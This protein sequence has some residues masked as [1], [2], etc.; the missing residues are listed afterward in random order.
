[1]ERNGLAALAESFALDRAELYRL[2]LLDRQMFEHLC[3]E[4]TLLSGTPMR[5]VALSLR[6][7]DYS[8]FAASLWPS[9][10]VTVID[11]DHRPVGL[12][13]MQNQIA[14][15]LLWDDSHQSPPAETDQAGPKG[16]TKI[17]A[18]V[19]AETVGG[20]ALSAFN[21]VFRPLFGIAAAVGRGDTDGKLDATA[22]VLGNRGRLATA[23]VECT[24]GEIR[25]AMFFTLLISTI[26]PVRAKLTRG[27]TD[28]G[29]LE[30]ASK[31]APPSSLMGANL[32][33]SAIL[34][35]SAMQLAD[36]RALKPGAIISLGET[37]QPVP[38]LELRY[39][40]QPLFS[41][42]VVED[43]GWRRFLIEEKRF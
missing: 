1:M 22:N 30:S 21:H 41:G 16:F 29:A 31:T 12:F 24:M 18:R 37:R 33:M 26:H 32:E 7:E 11:L 39:A 20:T 36:I 38:R 19:L 35:S 23:A 25:G 15:R 8:D 28:R 40:G 3:K 17:E 43:Q 13:G 10:F 4:I 2:T 6:V 27:A 14:E 9:G 42:T 34:G 5:I